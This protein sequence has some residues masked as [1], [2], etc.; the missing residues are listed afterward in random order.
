[1]AV[2]ALLGSLPIGT[3]HAQIFW[4]NLQ[5]GVFS[6][7]SNWT[8]GLAPT[9][10]QVAFFSYPT[11]SQIVGVNFTQ[12]T[13]TSSLQVDQ[14]FTVFNLGGNTYSLVNPGFGLFI[15]TSGIS[16]GLTGGLTLIDGRLSTT[17]GIVGTSAGTIPENNHTLTLGTG[18][19]LVV[20]DALLVGDRGTG[21][22]VINSGGTLDARELRLGTT[23]SGIGGLTIDGPTATAN[24]GGATF[25][26]SGSSTV[27]INHGGT[28]NVTSGMIL[29]NAG[30]NSLVNIL[31]ENSSLNLNG[32]FMVSGSGTTDFR[33]F[34]GRLGALNSQISLGPNASLLIADEGRFEMTGSTVGGIQLHGGT[35][36]VDRNSSANITDPGGIR[37]FNGGMLRLDVGTITTSNLS[38]EGGTFDYVR[39]NM[40]VNSGS[41]NANGNFAFGG[42]A[43][44]GS[45]VFALTNGA[46][47]NG[48]TSLIVGN[49][50]N[51][52]LHQ[53]DVLSG[54]TLTTSALSTIGQLGSNSF[55]RVSGPGSTWNASNIISV[56]DGG[57]GT[58]IVENG[59]RM[60]TNGN[61][62]FTG[63]AGAVSNGTVTVQSGGRI[64]AGSI[65]LARVA[66]S[67]SNATI[68][69][70]GTTVNA[71]GL[72]AGGSGTVEGGTATLAI[73]DGAQVNIAGTLRAR[74]AGTITLDGGNVTTQAF[75][76]NATGVMNYRNGSLTVLNSYSNNGGD[77]TIAGFGVNDNP[78]L[79]LAG[80]ALTFG[81]NNATIG[82][83]TRMGS[84]S[85]RNNAQLT[86]G[87]F[88]IGNMGTVNLEGG[89]L[90]VNSFANNGTF[91][92]NQG[93][94]NF[95]SST[96]L[97]NTAL[98]L[99]LGSGR[100]LGEGRTLGSLGGT[101]TL[102]GSLNV[103]GGTL[104]P[105]DL[106]NN[107]TL[108]VNQGQVTTSTMTNNAGRQILVGGNSNVNANTEIQNFGSIRMN[109]PTASLSGGQL[110]NNSGGT[111]SGTGQI[112]NVLFNE[113]LVRS[114]GAEHLIFTGA[115]NNNLASINLSG[116]TIEF[117]QDLVNRSGAAI[118]GRGTLFTSSASP[119]DLGLINDGL[120]SFSAGIADIYGDVDQFS[121]G[122]IVTSGNGVTTFFDDVIHNGVEIR[123]FLGSTTVF[124]GDQSGAGNF[125]GP[126]T[127]EYAGDLR[128]GNSPASISYEGDVFF[129]SSVRSFFELGGLNAGEFDQLL[130]DGDFNVDGS[131]FVS[132]INGHTLGAN[133]FYLIGDVRGNLTGQFNGLSEGSLVGNFG[134]RDLFITYSAGNGNDIGLFTAVPEPSTL[135]LAGFFMPLLLT[136]RR[137]RARAAT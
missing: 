115:G 51:S 42:S 124:L 73:R 49:L 5:G 72:F 79:V 65:E 137:R 81:I 125:T 91:Q 61:A 55:V 99:M 95:Q 36:T 33:V 30:S 135:M 129:N 27:T 114:T 92:W 59:G 4:Q 40:T 77:V 133:D 69:G 97:N 128:P 86:T 82:S 100:S 63:V 93:T 90:L 113:G 32:A 98:T 131:L 67:V 50:N 12:P 14:G 103:N 26:D 70:A 116:G 76:R 29:G 96:T 134:G 64:D 46:T 16:P 105:F 58:L 121:N 104:N 52:N 45:S 132:L 122:R 8:G 68:T 47:T 94:V 23:T 74:N 108:A 107:S 10:G 66:G 31:G 127:V 118:T 24:V 41:F 13:T 84:L 101:M 7:G 88:T 18:S 120:I 9:P 44:S 110:T 22:L 35:F 102:D 3:S 62:L 56:G 57:A 75:I 130:I 6:Q 25:G 112:D 37:I 85:V 38:L 83:S 111:I 54:S 60:N 43:A 11:S 126:G 71:N 123:T 20:S 34:G 17:S 80:N 87:A 109:S 106:T 89:R 53:F 28:L 136:Q 21:S 48:L 78:H 119:G 1:M 39:G 19:Q 2:L 15:G 117:S